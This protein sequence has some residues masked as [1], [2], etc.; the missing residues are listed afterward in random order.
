MAKLLYVTNVSVNGC[1][2]DERGSITWSE[3]DDDLFAFITDLVRPVGT[4]LYGRRLYDTMAMWE[5]DPA[6]AAASRLAADFADVWRAADKVV[7]STT[8]TTPP[9]ARTRVERT[10]D[11]TSVRDLKAAA[12]SDLTVGG[13]ELAAQAFRA[14][15]VDECHL[16]VRPVVLGGGKPA[17]PHGV[18]VDLELLD[19]RAVG[20]GS[21]HLRYRVGV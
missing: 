21:V 18:R 2:E 3:P 12:T 5:T 7:Y 17:L 10:F 20:R 1:I 9:T 19:A 6:L 4:H 14:G 11:A 13:A 16:I 15:L 8:L